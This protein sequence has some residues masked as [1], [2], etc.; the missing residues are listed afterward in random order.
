MVGD[1]RTLLNEFLKAYPN[2]TR[3]DAI[4]YANQQ[5]PNSPL[6]IALFL[7]DWLTFREKLESAVEGDGEMD[8]PPGQ[9]G[10]AAGVSMCDNNRVE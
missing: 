2:A 5:F 10:S 3:Q 9:N 8:N 6:T 7:A 4:E 1:P